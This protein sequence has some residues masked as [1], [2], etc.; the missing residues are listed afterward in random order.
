MGWHSDN[1]LDSYLEGAQFGLDRP[2]T[3]VMDIIRDFP[4]SLQVNA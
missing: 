1:A 4:Q 2:Q 3:I